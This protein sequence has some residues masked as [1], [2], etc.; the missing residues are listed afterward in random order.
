MNR[1]IWVIFNQKAKKSFD[2]KGIFFE[3]IYLAKIN[4]FKNLKK[5]YFVTKSVLTYCEK[6]LF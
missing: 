6:K 3:S 5:K 1:S 4:Y 2:V